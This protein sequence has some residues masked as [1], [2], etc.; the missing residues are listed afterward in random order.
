MFEAICKDKLAP[1]M[2]R[3]ALGLIC[4]THGYLKIMA[5]GGTN[6]QPGMAVGWQLVIAW[7]EFAAGLAVLV[8]FRCRLFAALAIVIVAGTLTWWQ[9]WGVLRLPIR[10]LEPTLLVLF[11]GGALLLLGG[12]ELSVDGK[13]M[14][15]AMAR[16]PARRR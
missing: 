12:G 16:A 5:T 2:L 3:L 10:S 14:G 13:S 1:L 9:G 6:W 15:R 7:G 8:G 11:I 4:V